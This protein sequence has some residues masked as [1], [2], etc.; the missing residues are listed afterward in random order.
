MTPLRKFMLVCILGLS[1]WILWILLL[2]RAQIHKMPNNSYEASQMSAPQA[3]T[4]IQDWSKSGAGGSVEGFS[5]DADTSM[6]NQQINELKLKTSTSIAPGIKS[7]NVVDSGNLLLREYCIKAS[8]NSA[9]TGTY[10]NLDMIKY[11]L[12]RGCRFL[13]FEL[14]FIDT[15]TPNLVDTIGNSKQPCVAFSNDPAGGSNDPTG[16]VLKSKNYLRLSNVFQR[17]REYAFQAPTPNVNDPL[18]IQLRIYSKEKEMYQETANLIQRFFSMNRYTQDVDAS[19]TKIVDIMKS[20][21]FVLDKNIADFQS[22]KNT[23]LPKY[24]NMYSGGTHLMKY[25]PK[26]LSEMLINMNQVIDGTHLSTVRGYSMVEPTKVVDDAALVPS[27]YQ[28][29]LWV[30]TLGALNVGGNDALNGLSLPFFVRN[31]GAQIVEYPL[32]RTG[33]ALVN[34][35]QFFADM[36]AAFVPMYQAL[37]YIHQN[38]K[39][40]INLAA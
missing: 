7:Y 17:I 13:D 12:S 31:Y 18:F 30:I 8:Y 15:T 32:Y 19:T 1:T 11:V 23:D 33:D 35:E 38:P 40:I 28:W 2:Q 14:Y 10:V 4:I 20:V 34:Y 36:G 21:I 26:G 39:G 16:M 9:C 29:F 22:Y 37:P 6:T 27:I 3:Q 24:I 5:G 25:S